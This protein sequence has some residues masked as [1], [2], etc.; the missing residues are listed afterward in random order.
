MLLAVVVGGTV[1]YSV[2]GLAPLDALYMTVTTISTVGFRELGDV[3]ARYRAVTIALILV[4]VS[5][6]LY[7]FGVVMEGLIEGRLQDLLGR[8]RMTR[9][10]SRMRGHIVIC[11]GGRVGRE[12]VSECRARQR[13]LVVIDAD[14]AALERFGPDVPFV[15]GDARSDA[16]LE[17]AG[18]ERAGV[19]FATLSSDADNVYVVLAA[20][21]MNPGLFIVARAHDLHADAKLRQAGADRVVNPQFI[22]GRRMATYALN[23][24]VADFLDVVVEEAGVEWQ[25]NEIV[26]GERSPFAGLSLAAADIRNSTGALVLALRDADGHFVTNPG[27][28]EVLLPGCVVIAIGTPTQLAALARAEGAP[29]R[30]AHR[31]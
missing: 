5:T 9:D 22:G 29:E 26:V 24:H 23:P 13:E 30:R 17:E 2:L 28:D 25:L 16:V 19:L 31:P 27:R 11:G 21:A 7:T 18:V 20:R 3:D 6:A 8:R 4:G 1:A 10:I 12:L 15:S 14:A